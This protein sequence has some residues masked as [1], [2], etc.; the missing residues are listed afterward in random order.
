[1]TDSEIQ[2]GAAPENAVSARPKRAILLVIL[3]LA[4][5]GTRMIRL[6]E[7][8]FH[9]DESIHAFQSWTLAKDGTWRYDPAYHGPFLYY[10]NA[11]VYKIFGAT[12]FTARVL[13]AIFGLILIGFA[14][15]LSRWIGRKAATAYAVLVLLAPHLN[16]FSRFIR[17]DLYSLVFTLGTILAFRMFL[18][19]DRAKWL[20]LSAVA[21]ALAGV[22]KEN[23]YMTGVLFV[24][25]G[26]WLLVERVLTWRPDTE[27]GSK[28]VDAAINWIVARW[29]PFVTAGIVFLFIW[30][31]MYTAFFRYPDDV[32][33]SN[34]LGIR[35]AV[36]YW[37]GQHTIARIPGP[38]YYYFPQLAYYETAICFAALFILVRAD[39]RR[40]PFVR[41]VAAGMAALAVYAEAQD[42]LSKSSSAALRLFPAVLLAAGLLWSLSLLRGRARSAPTRAAL[43]RVLMI[44]V[45]ASIAIVVWLRELRFLVPLLV[46][47]AVWSLFRLLRPAQPAPPT[48][49]QPFLRFLIYWALASLAI[50]GWAREKVPWLTVH[51]LLPITILAAIALTDLWERRQARGAQLAIATTLVLLAINSYGMY[52]ACFRYGAYD[53]EYQPKHGEYLAYVQTTED[54]V[55]AIRLAD[56][57]RGRVAAGQSIVTVTG[58]ATWPLTWYLRDLPTSWVPS[59]ETASTPMIVADWNP[60]GGLD[61]QLAE[62]YTATRLPIR[63]W[64]FPDDFWQQSLRNR[65]RWWL[66]HEL[67]TPAS[68][69][70]DARTPIGSQDA[71][72]YVRRDLDTSAS[73]LTP[74]EITVRDTSGRDY[75][76]DAKSIPPSRTQG[77]AGAGPGEFAEP[78]GIAADARGNIYVADT[79]N[80]RIQVFDSNGQ[81]LRQFGSF[82]S[83]PGQFKEPCG[84]AV[85]SQGDVWVAD[86]WNA[87]VVHLASDGRVLGVLGPPEDTLFG[88]RAI[89]VVGNVV[90]VAD[91]GNK[92]ILRYDRQGK[93]LSEF[94]GP[95]SNPGQFVEPVGLAADGTGNIYVADTGNHRV[96]VFDPE[97][98]FIRQFRV[99]GWKDFYTEPYIAVGPADT[100]FVTDAWGTRVAQYD[101]SGDVQRSWRA[102][103]DWKSPT[104]IAIDPFGRLTVS[105]R[106]TN[107][108][109]SWSLDTLLH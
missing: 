72:L 80:S 7:R 30:I 31:T 96:Q 13:P 43:L 41:S 86:T 89:V 100:V 33:F 88:P 87:R 62:R 107:R 27:T 3:L 83:E 21:F 52:L 6:G 10:A 28:A 45:L 55:R 39:V 70:P 11:L 109:F 79:K 38:W 74:L 54:L 64:W 77:A 23:A 40:D 98:K 25:F 93:K 46:A 37:I 63:A 92:R 78:R 36:Q 61:K 22:T 101:L 69:S 53:L 76:S 104:G 99:F 103:H 66:F 108:L 84:V 102:D 91:T 32:S 57:K 15:P 44:S 2:A 16:Y 105:D 97:G 4:A 9:H 95:G 75:P 60:E 48:R 65:L 67:W 47:A 90:Y 26:M 34:W 20:T 94:G 71:V 68:F 24:V 50:Y 5:L 73:L 49:T 81:L 12:N 85:D 8:P 106:G 51:P 29:V 82:G 14:W 18:E 58:E 1:M 19:T 17:E 42:V 59:L 56:Q 35:K